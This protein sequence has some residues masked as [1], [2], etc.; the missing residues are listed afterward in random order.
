[1]VNQIDHAV[2]EGNIMRNEDEGVFVFD[3]IAFQPFDVIF[4]QIVGRL[5]QKK[6]I[7][8][9]IN[10]LAETDLCLFSTAQY[11]FSV[12]PKAL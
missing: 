8:I 12:R 9:S 6:N 11:P 4:V 5:I 3:Q 2:K 1:M 7:G 10:Q